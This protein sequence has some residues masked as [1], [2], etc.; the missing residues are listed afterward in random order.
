MKPFFFVIAIFFFGISHAQV[1]GT[2][3]PDLEA[4]NVDD[5]KI[6]LPV[7]VKGKYT[8]IGMALRT[9]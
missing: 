8:L 5:K 6:K 7:D 9:T 2:V 4:E 1:I 3:F